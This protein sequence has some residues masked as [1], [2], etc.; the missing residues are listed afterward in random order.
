MSRA[1]TDGNQK[2]IIGSCKGNIETQAF[3]ALLFL[4]RNVL[5]I[6]LTAS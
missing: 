4:N 3:N 1:I 6:S 5:N 2:K